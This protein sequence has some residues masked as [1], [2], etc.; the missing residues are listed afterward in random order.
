MLIGEGYRT[1]PT[2]IYSEFISE[3]GSNANFSASMSVIM[4]IITTIMF[5]SQKYI[6]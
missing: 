2:M 6:V 5:I 1:M 3:V 4:V